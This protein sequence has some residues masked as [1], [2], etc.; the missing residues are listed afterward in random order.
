MHT[1]QTMMG[2]KANG[3]KSVDS[4]PHVKP[5]KSYAFTHYVNVYRDEEGKTHYSTEEFSL[6][7]DGIFSFDDALDDAYCLSVLGE[8]E[9]I[10]TMTDNGVNV[11]TKMKSRLG[12]LENAATILK[13]FGD[14]PEKYSMEYILQEARDIVNGDRRKS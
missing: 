10:S 11:T 13:N 8:W 4:I 14:D 5:V 7:Q 3:T 9:Y 12:E 2:F 1:T 6:N